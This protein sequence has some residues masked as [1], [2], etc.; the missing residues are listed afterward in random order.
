MSVVGV[1]SVVS[2]VGVVVVVVFVCVLGVHGTAP[3]THDDK[4]ECN[5]KLF[6]TPSGDEPQAKWVYYSLQVQWH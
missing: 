2:V 1:V 6:P 4:Q 5:H 3:R